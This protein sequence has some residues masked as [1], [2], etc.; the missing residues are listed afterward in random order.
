MTTKQIVMQIVKKLPADASI[1]DAMEKLF[2][3][4]KIEKGIYQADSGKTVSNECVKGRVRK[5][6]K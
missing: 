4:A 1:E 3:L 6:L 2:F 5:W